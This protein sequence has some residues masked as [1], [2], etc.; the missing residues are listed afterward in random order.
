MGVSGAK[1]RACP[2][3][4]SASAGACEALDDISVEGVADDLRVLSGC[5]ARAASGTVTA[6]VRLPQQQLMAIASYAL[7][8]L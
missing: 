1:T 2:C 8:A 5:D 6:M 4:I 7:R 3:P